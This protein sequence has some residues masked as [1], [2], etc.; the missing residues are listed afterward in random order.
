MGDALM[1]QT[2]PGVQK[3]EG[4]RQPRAASKGVLSRRNRDALT[5]DPSLM[6]IRSL[7]LLVVLVLSVA[8]C[9]GFV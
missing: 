7:I 3:Q 1:G 6:R 8:I 4:A 5:K 2:G 9:L